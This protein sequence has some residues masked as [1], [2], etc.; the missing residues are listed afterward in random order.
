ME[1]RV[2]LLIKNLY[3]KRILLLDVSYSFIIVFASLVGGLYFDYNRTNELYLSKIEPA[4]AVS[5]GE[6]QCNCTLDLLDNTMK[7]ELPNVEIVKNE[8]MQSQTEGTLKWMESK[9]LAMD[10]VLVGDVYLANQSAGALVDLNT[11]RVRKNQLLGLEVT[12]GI[13]PDTVKVEIVNSLTA[14]NSTGLKIG[15]IQI[16]KKISESDLLFY[17]SIKK[18]TLDQNSFKLQIPTQGEAVLIVSLLY[19]DNDTGINNTRN[20]AT[21]IHTQSH[22]P[23]LIGI[24]KAILSIKG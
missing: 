11:M 15:D 19:N 9:Q 12:G 6:S 23:R 8:S 5:K 1:Q 3:T 2:Y 20:N 7:F 16:D 21:T 4:Y 14:M 22:A 18:P 24:Y 17:K 13:L 10:G